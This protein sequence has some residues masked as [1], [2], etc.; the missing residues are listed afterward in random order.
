MPKTLGQPG[1][2]GDDEAFLR[3]GCKGGIEQRIA[4]QMGQAS[5]LGPWSTSSAELP[6]R[7]RKGTHH[8]SRRAA[9]RSSP[10]LAQRPGR[11]IPAPPPVENF[12]SRCRCPE[13]CSVAH[14]WWCP[15]SGGQV[16]FVAKFPGYQRFISACA[17][18][19]PCPAFSQAQM[20]PKLRFPIFT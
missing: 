12:T 10:S 13:N 7:P 6:R 20:K 14:P 19:C 17:W 15:N 16:P 18:S 2:K 4:G 5:C 3:A 9:V 1:R 8:C 11:I